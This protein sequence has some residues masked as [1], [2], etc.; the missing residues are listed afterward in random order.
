MNIILYIGWDPAEKEAFEI[1]EYSIQRRTKKNILIYPLVLQKLQEERLYYRNTIIRDNCLW[2][3]ISDAPMSTEFA[4][5]R[6]FIPLLAKKEKQKPDW[7][8]FC[9]SDFLWLAGIEELL[10]NVDAS[11]A[12][13]CVQHDYNPHETVKMLGKTQTSYPRKNWSSLM[14]FNLKHPAHDKLTIEY[15]NSVP[16]RELHRFAWLKDD[17]IGSLN[18]L[19]NWLEGHYSRGDILPK[20]IHYTRGGPWM[21]EWKNVDYAQYWLDERAL[22]KEQ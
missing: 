13:W 5:S 12:L 14:I 8:I 22:F 21:D 16:G 2:D 6:F 3:E 11:K 18:Y 4:I 19:W 7:A 10:M 20:A 15:L 17:E 9:D 1:C